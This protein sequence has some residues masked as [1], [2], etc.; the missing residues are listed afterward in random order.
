MNKE[1]LTF[2][3][4]EDA[5][6][7]YFRENCVNDEQIHIHT[8]V[9]NNGVQMR[10]MTILEKGE[11]FAPTVYLDDFYQVYLKGVP[12]E[13]VLNHLQTVYAARKQSE[14]IEIQYFY[15]YDTVRNTLRIKIINYEKNR[16]F[17]EDVPHMR[18][19]D[20]AV[21]C[22]SQVESEALRNGSI[23][24]RESHL[25]M[26][27]ITKKQLFLDGV[28]ESVSHLPHLLVK[29]TALL[30]E[31][32]TEFPE[33]LR[34]EFP[35]EEDEAGMRIL[36]NCQKINGA[37]AIFYPG[38]LEECA[39]HIGSDYYILPS[40]IHEVILVPEKEGSFELLSSMVHDVN[41]EQLAVEEILSNHVYYYNQKKGTIQDLVTKDSVRVREV[42]LE[43]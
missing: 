11:K 19:L 30:E 21:I 38:V 35:I 29:M 25:K 41:D 37:A 31:I 8:I 6:R 34:I 10:G 39:K 43:E 7:C 1:G 3:Q 20:L 40:S 5:V 17:L 23:I 15:Q 16:Q 13:S 27:Q 26:W 24:V 14:G 2:E 28:M 4:F 12:V 18:F 9:K 22:Y 36:T 42:Q 33:E 32:Q